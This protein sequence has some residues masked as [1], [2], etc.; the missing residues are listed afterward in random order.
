[1]F[2]IFIM[3]VLIWVLLGDIHID[4]ELLYEQGE[5][6]ENERER[7]FE[8]LKSL[9]K[10]RKNDRT[11][12]IG[13]SSLKKRVVRRTRRVVKR[14]EEMGMEEVMEWEEGE[15]EEED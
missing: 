3:L 14:G 4:N 1:M 15:F 9:V 8:E 5:E 7:E 2:G 11:K 12:R 13:E 10:G 6:Y